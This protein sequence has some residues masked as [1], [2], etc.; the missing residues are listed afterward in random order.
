L[1][2]FLFRTQL[3]HRDIA[4]TPFTIPHDAVD[5]VGFTFLAE[6]IQRVASPLIWGDW[7]AN[8][9]DNCAA[10]DVLSSSPITIWKCYARTGL[11]PWSVKQR[12]V[13]PTGHLSNEKLAEFFATR[14]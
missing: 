11:Y 8:V 1:E 13:A 4:V 9:K 2:F 5:P 3:S 7:L 10:C 12:V 6:G 14:V